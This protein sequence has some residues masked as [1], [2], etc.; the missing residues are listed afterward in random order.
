M[1]TKYLAARFFMLSSLA[2]T[3]YSAQ[4]QETA[5]QPIPLVQGTQVGK[6]MF[7][8]GDTARG[9]N[10][11]PVD[12]I[13]GSSQEM[14]KVHFHAHLSLFYKGEQIA[15]PAGIGIVKPLRID[16]G[17]AGGGKGFYWLHTHDATGILHI[18]SPQVKNYT[19]AN[20][21]DIWGEQLTADNVAGMHGTVRTFVNGRLQFGGPGDIVLH[22]HDQITL[23]IG[24]PSRPVPTYV[25]PDGL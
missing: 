16:H 23:E 25:F 12:G 24:E 6:T 15:V 13:E 7:E 5:G 19:L 1:R 9:G 17:F 10:G 21:F 20:F 4:A 11:R 2:A 14:L 8:P 22:D 3:V 18:E